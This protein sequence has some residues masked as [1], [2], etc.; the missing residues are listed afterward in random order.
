MPPEKIRQLM[1]FIHGDKMAHVVP[2]KEDDGDPPVG[3]SLPMG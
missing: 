3:P 2:S 1:A